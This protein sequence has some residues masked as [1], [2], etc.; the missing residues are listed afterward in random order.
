[1]EYFDATALTARLTSPPGAAP[2]F[3]DARRGGPGTAAAVTKPT[4]P[5]AAQIT[6]GLP[7]IDSTAIAAGQ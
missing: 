2:E 6:R 1:M 5:S 3:R 4:V 7:L